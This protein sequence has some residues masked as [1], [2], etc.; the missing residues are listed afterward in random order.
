MTKTQVSKTFQEHQKVTIGY[1]VQ[2]PFLGSVIFPTFR[3]ESITV[4]FF[5]EGGYRCFAHRSDSSTAGLR[6]RKTVQDVQLGKERFGDNVQ[7]VL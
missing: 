4:D 7:A 5:G 1:D 6:Q 3:S 2:L